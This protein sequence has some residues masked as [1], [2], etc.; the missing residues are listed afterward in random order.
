VRGS[1]IGVH[2]RGAVLV[3]QRLLFAQPRVVEK[4]A[5]V[6]LDGPVGAN[7]PDVVRHAFGDGCRQIGGVGRHGDFLLIAVR[8][9]RLCARYAQAR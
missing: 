8:P 4:L 1:V 6:V 7:D 3:R 5:V 9:K 2:Q